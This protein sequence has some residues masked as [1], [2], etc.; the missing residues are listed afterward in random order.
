VQIIPNH[1]VF[2]RVLIYIVNS[3]LIKREIAILFIRKLSADKRDIILTKKR[4]KIIPTSLYNNYLF[5]YLKDIL[6]N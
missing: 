2:V 3:Y 5:N 6:V 1:V 4:E